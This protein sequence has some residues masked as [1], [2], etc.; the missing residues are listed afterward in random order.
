M[1]TIS[2]CHKKLVP[3]DVRQ[4]LGAIPDDVVEQFLAACK[5]S[6]HDQLY[7]CVESIRREGYGVYQLLKQFFYICLH[8]EDINDLNKATICEKIGVSFISSFFSPCLTHKFVVEAAIG[9]II[10]LVFEDNN[11]AK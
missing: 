9:K 5:S 3:T 2:S 11:N 8:L 10:Y 7:T 1:Q 4:F 6:N